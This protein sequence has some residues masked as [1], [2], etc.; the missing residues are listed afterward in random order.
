L[1]DAIV[2]ITPT[3][4]ATGMSGKFERMA[5]FLKSYTGR[6]MISIQF[7]PGSSIHAAQVA[8]R[9]IADLAKILL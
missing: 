4:V 7:F 1:P 9:Q 5:N 6:V 8:K 3:F 2:V